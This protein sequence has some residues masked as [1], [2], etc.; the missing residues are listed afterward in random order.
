M[1]ETL[2]L[3]N[4]NLSVICSKSPSSPNR[5]QKMASFFLIKIIPETKVSK[6]T[7]MGEIIK[8]LMEGNSRL[9]LSVFEENTPKIFFK[10]RINNQLINIY[11]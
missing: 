9:R 3:A 5:Y 10:W 4:P 1:S 7:G 6:A 11:F 2:G 8:E